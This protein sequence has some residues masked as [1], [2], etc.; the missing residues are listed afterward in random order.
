MLKT[1]A[2]KPRAISPPKFTAAPSREIKL[3][4]KCACGGS[5]GENDACPSCRSASLGLQRKPATPTQNP[6]PA[7]ASP[8]VGQ[9]LR[10]PGQS[11]GAP[12]R[13]FMEHRFGHDFSRIHIHTDSRAA[14]SA[15]AVRALAYTVG[16]H[17]IFAPNQ[18]QP[19]THA[20][21]NLLAHELA[22]TIQQGTTDGQSLDR[23][24]ITDPAGPAEHAADRAASAALAGAASTAPSSAPLEKSASPAI[25]RRTPPLDGGPNDDNTDRDVGPVPATTPAPATPAEPDQLN[26]KSDHLIAS[27]DAEP[28]APGPWKLNE[29]P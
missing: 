11:I 18:F 9:V 17:V 5:A 8:L 26:D 14:A 3:E 7:I 27:F 4:R 12:L 29:L 24:P 28:P 15:Q 23:L 2:Q 16:Q 13:T 25:A 20:G 6:H 10:S 21:R 1:P 19:N 22:H